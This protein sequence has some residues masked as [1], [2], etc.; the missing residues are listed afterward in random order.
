MHC[1]DQAKGKHAGF[2]YLTLT[3]L[4]NWRSYPHALLLAVDVITE[5]ICQASLL[6]CAGLE[7]S[8]AAVFRLELTEPFCHSF[9]NSDCKIK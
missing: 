9:V 4:D 1:L 8:S 6:Q 2:R 7:S 5:K 3:I